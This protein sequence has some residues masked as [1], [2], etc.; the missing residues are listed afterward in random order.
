MRTRAERRFNT[1]R[2]LIHR[3]NMMK[4][5]GQQGGTVYDKHIAKIN[6][7]L[8]YMR[9]GNVSHYVSCGFGTRTKNS[10]RRGTPSSLEYKPR[11]D[12]KV[13][14]QRQIDKENIECMY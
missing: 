14:D 7:S 12:Y 5:L 6:K 13:H 1:E 3:K 4:K 10:S 11:Y 2:K 8:G 9:D